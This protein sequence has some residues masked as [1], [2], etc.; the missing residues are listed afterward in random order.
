NTTETSAT[1]TGAGGLAV[2]GAGGLNVVGN[3]IFSGTGASGSN[4]TLTNTG[5]SGNY[6]AYFLGYNATGLSNGM[7]LNAG[8]NSSDMAFRVRNNGNTAEYFAVRGDGNIG[9]GTT[10]PVGKLDLFS[11]D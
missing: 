1:A 9:I 6:A 7:I 11:P 3:G 2:T 10:G 4:N 5:S 8:T